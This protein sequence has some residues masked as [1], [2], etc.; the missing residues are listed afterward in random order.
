[1]PGATQEKGEGHRQCVVSCSP[2][3]WRVLKEGPS[4]TSLVHGIAED[5]GG[6]SLVAL[7]NMSKT[8]A[9][10]PRFSSPSDAHSQ[11]LF[12]P[13]SEVYLVTLLQT[14]V[15]NVSQVALCPWTKTGGIKEKGRLC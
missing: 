14:S 11:P 15:V 5:M 9:V 3:I 13:V 2:R 6:C 8:H 12:E 7:C 10:I 4:G 1:M